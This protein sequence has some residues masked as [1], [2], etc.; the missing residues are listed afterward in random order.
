MEFRSWVGTK[1][2]SRDPSFPIFS[3]E[4]WETTS[5]KF[6]SLRLLRLLLSSAEP[7]EPAAAQIGQ[8]PVQVLAEVPLERADD[9]AVDDRL[10]DFA[11]DRLEW[12]PRPAVCV[13]IDPKLLLLRLRKLRA[14]DDRTP[15]H[16]NRVAPTRF[17]EYGDFRRSV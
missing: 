15:L 8:E 11:E 10:G 12:D 13:V 5:S 2:S 14:E 1:R 3:T 7:L 17:N 6:P 4:E 16:A 9:A